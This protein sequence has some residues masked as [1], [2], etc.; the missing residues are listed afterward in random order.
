MAEEFSSSYLRIFPPKHYPNTKY[1]H[2]SNHHSTNGLIFY[3]RKLSPQ[4]HFSSH[5]HSLQFSSIFLLPN[6]STSTSTILVP[7][8]PPVPQVSLESQHK[9]SDALSYAESTASPAAPRHFPQTPRKASTGVLKSAIC[10]SSHASYRSP[11]SR[12]Q[13]HSEQADTQVKAPFHPSSIPQ[14]QQQL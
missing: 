5:E 13:V 7:Q 4:P 2:L 6:E 9:T 14:F 8:R 11:S 3:K 10:L 12:N 1:Y